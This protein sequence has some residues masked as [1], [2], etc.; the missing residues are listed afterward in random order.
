[1][2]ILGIDQT[3]A[4]SGWAYLDFTGGEWTLLGYGTIVTPANLKGHKGTFDRSLVLYHEYIQLLTSINPQ[5]VA[6]ELPAVGGSMHRP[7]SSLIAGALLRIAVAE[8]C[9]DAIIDVVGAQT[10][11]KHI[12]NNGNCS[13]QQMGA[14]VRARMD[15][16]TNASSDMKCNEHVRDAIALALTSCERDR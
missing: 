6:W 7:E 4:N 13:K 16:I 1:M 5:T 15:S 8:A 14:G 10:A 12:T 3:L 11:K 9:P 2:R